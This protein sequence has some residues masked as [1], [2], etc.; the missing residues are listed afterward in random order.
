MQK[1]YY[2]NRMTKK[3]LAPAP[4]RILKMVFSRDATLDP[5]E[6]AKALLMTAL[7]PAMGLIFIVLVMG[8]IAA[9]V[10]TPLGIFF[11]GSNDSGQNTVDVIVEINGEYDAKV[12]GMINS[13]PHDEVRYDGEKAAWRDVIA[14]YA[15]TNNLTTAEADVVEWDDKK[16]RALSKVFWDMTKLSSSTMTGKSSSSATPVSS[17]Q[18]EWDPTEWTKDDDEDADAVKTVVLT[19]TTTSKTATD[20]ALEYSFT[21]DE[22]E[23]LEEILSPEF[24]AEWEAILGEVELM[25]AGNVVI[26]NGTLSWPCQGTITSEYGWRI[27][28]NYG[29]KQLHGGIDIA[30]PTGTPIHAAEDGTVSFAGWKGS[31]GNA[32]I[33]DHGGS[34]GSSVSTLYGHNSSLAVKAGAKVKRGDTIAYA[35]STGNSTG[36]HCHFEVRI[37]G[38]AKNPRSYL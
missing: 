1:A 32:V 24:D 4:V 10:A 25:E 6:W 26:G 35:G 29:T 17:A 2:I 28:P 7:I 30:V 27:R 23:T 36:P 22:K 12:A 3:Y 8:A 34:L 37:N 21:A 11:S 20:M 19:I 5:V 14:V 33:I 16:K 13:T 9:L 18:Q 31:Y 38:V 15:I